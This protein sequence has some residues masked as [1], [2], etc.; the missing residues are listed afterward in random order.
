M[1]LS[2]FGG[3]FQGQIIA[4]SVFPFWETNVTGGNAQRVNRD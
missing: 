4:F 1:M 2:D 3:Y